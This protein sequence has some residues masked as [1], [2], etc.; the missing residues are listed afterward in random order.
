MRIWRVL[1]KIPEYVNASYSGY[2]GIK[3]TI[4]PKSKADSEWRVCRTPDITKS[5]TDF[6]EE[7]LQEIKDTRSKSFG[8]IRVLWKMARNFGTAEPWD[9]KFLAEFPGRNRKGEVQYARYKDEI[10]SGND[11]SNL[12]FGHVCAFVGIPARLAKLVARLD[13]S[14]VIEPF[15][16]GRFPNMQLLKFRDTASDQIAIEKGIKEFNIGDYRLR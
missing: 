9:T 14:G 4:F 2:T 12:F 13:A 11:V 5:L 1:N 6:E 16:K 7:V 8:F 15:T 10:L 3:G